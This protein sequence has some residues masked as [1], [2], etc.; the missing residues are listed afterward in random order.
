MICIQP[1]AVIRRL[2]TELKPTTFKAE[3]VALHQLLRPLNRKLCNESCSLHT[4]SHRGDKKILNDLNA[5]SPDKGGP[6]YPLPSTTAG[7]RKERVATA[8]EKIFLLV[9]VLLRGIL[10]EGRSVNSLHSYLCCVLC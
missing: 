1:E 8:V 3:S 5:A 2:S 10:V 7:K 6:K 4:P 9:S